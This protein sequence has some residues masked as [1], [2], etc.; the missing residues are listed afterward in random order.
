MDWTYGEDERMADYR[1]EGR[2]DYHDIVGEVEFARDAHFQVRAEGEDRDPEEQSE[3]DACTCG[4]ERCGHR[5]PTRVAGQW[6]FGSCRYVKCT[7][8][9]FTFDWSYFE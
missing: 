6:V 9:K 5:E 7:C 3:G 1:S 8:L 2:Y 4:H